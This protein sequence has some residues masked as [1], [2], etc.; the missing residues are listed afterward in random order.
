MPVPG[1]LLPWAMA[2]MIS[3]NVRTGQDLPVRTTNTPHFLELGAIMALVGPQGAQRQG[4]ILN[5]V[6]LGTA[7][8]TSGGSMTSGRL[9]RIIQQA[10]RE[11]MFDGLDFAREMVQRGWDFLC[12]N[13]QQQDAVG[14]N[15]Q[16]FFATLSTALTPISLRLIL[17][18]QQTD[19]K[20]LT[21]VVLTQ[22]AIT[23]Y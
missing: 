3:L 17:M 6:A 5:L 18:C 8:V 9:R 22:K 2:G 20:M 14:Q 4:A 21:G 16:E 19:L 1:E 12:L 23:G 7:I 13:F 15:F 11:M 10:A